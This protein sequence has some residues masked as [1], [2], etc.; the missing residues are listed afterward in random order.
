[1]SN[2]KEKINRS[3][4]FR[5]GSYSSLLTIIVVA[6]VVVVNLA[7]NSLPA[8][9]TT[10]DTSGVDYYSISDT[11]ESMLDELKADVNIYMLSDQNGGYNEYVESLC[12]VYAGTSD[13]VNF[14]KVDVAVKPGFAAGYDAAANSYY[15]LIVENNLTGKFTVIDYSDIYYSKTG[16]DSSG[17]QFYTYY[18]DGEGQISSAINYVTSNKSIKLYELGGHG[19]Q[20]ISE[21]PE[22]L[23]ALKKSN[24][25]LAEEQLN[26]SKG[27]TIPEDCEVL[28]IFSPASDYTKTETDTIKN[29]MKSGGNVIVIYNNVYSADMTNFYSLL[30]SV[31]I[32]VVEGL[33]IEKDPN[34]YYSAAEYKT[35]TL[36]PKKNV[37]NEILSELT[38]SYILSFYS[39]P[40]KQVETNE[41]DVKF[42]ELLSTSDDF[43]I[44]Y[45][46]EEQYTVDYTQSMPVSAYV[47]A[48]FKETNTSS[49]IMVLGS[50]MFLQDIVN[51]ESLLNNNAKF[52]TNTVKVMVNDED[53]IYVAPKSLDEKF[54]TTSQQKVNLFSIIYLGLIPLAVLLIGVSVT[55]LRRSK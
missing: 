16:Y 42:T 51:D 8:N 54:N 46:G 29:Y 7:I 37:K 6:I 21:Y 19:E 9:I 2:K 40:V 48:T 14:E 44:V 47:E 23:D 31:G 15:S 39:S 5:N 30:N 10:F 32:S 12:K 22:M 43:Q 17:T 34:F 35:Y 52:I 26:L 11:T 4:Q 50:A 24:Y 45:F 18:Y 13:K 38:N 49:N 20:K 1:M 41:C 25:T 55:V 53:S 33:I 27:D 36:L 3:I 28:F